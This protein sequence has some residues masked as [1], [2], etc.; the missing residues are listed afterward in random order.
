MPSVIASWYSPP[1]QQEESKTNDISRM[2][3]TWYMWLVKVNIS[4]ISISLPTLCT[5]LSSQ[6]S[7]V[8]V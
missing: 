1:V 6:R 7:S 4:K 8:L 2:L 3:D 5:Y